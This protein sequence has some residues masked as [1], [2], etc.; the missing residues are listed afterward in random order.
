MSHLNKELKKKRSDELEICTVTFQE[1]ALGPLLFIIYINDISYI[2]SDNVLI[3]VTQHGK[4]Y[5]SGGN[6]NML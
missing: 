1:T 2:M 3:F 5:P 4:R 6:G